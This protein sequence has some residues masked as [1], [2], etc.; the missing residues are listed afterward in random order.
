MAFTVVVTPSAQRDIDRLP[1]VVR[2]R[3]L[4]AIER[5]ANWPNVPNVKALKGGKGLYR[6]RV[7]DYRVIFYVDVAVVVVRVGHRKDVY[8]D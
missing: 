7:G 3:V 2:N 6:M 8:D 5:L 4:T 1:V